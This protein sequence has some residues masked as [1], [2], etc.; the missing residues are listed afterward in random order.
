MLRRLV[1]AALGVVAATG[2]A[3]ATRA[4]QARRRFESGERALEPAGTGIPDPHV[5]SSRHEDRP[6][7]IAAAGGAPAHPAPQVR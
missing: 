1:I 5:G 6:R 7:W 2:V 4:I 3:V